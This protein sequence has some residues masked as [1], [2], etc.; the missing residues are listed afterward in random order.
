VTYVR[1][2]RLIKAGFQ[3][4]DFSWRG[5]DDRVNRE[6]TFTFSSLQDYALGRPLSFAQQ[7][8]DGRMVFLQKGIRCVR[9]WSH[10][11]P[12]GSGKGEDAAA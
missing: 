5:F 8:G 1:R 4:P 2:K 3:V 10:E 12:I 6:G 9:R 11:F 7:Q